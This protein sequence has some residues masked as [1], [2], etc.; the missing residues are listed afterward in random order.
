MP[1]TLDRH[2]SNMSPDSP[3]SSSK[4]LKPQ[5]VLAC[6]ICQ[7]RKVKCERKFPCAN[8]VKSQVR[9]VPATL[10]Q[11]NRKR[12]FPERELLERLRRY[13][14]LLR[15]NDI[16][17]EPLHKDSAQETE[18]SNAKI[19]DGSDNEHPEAVGQGVPSTTLKSER[20]HQTKYALLRE[21]LQG[22]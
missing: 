2:I 5:R 11:R 3:S 18:P 4:V 7:Q 1:P 8:C 10:A 14:D 22:D 13:E 9:C 16:T 21:A 15:R 6:L 12:R 20:G 17:F 19:S